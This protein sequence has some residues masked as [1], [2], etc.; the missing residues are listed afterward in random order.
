VYVFPI[1]LPPLRERRE[2]VPALVEHFSAQISRQNG[3]KPA[4]FTPEAIAHLQAQP[5]TGNIRE[6]RNVVERL[7]LF[8]N[9]GVV[10][11]TT[12]ASALPAADSAGARPP[13]Q[14]STGTLADRVAAMERET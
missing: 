10:D 14:T 5:W 13:A 2:D 9:D 8:A 4:R 12:V 1:V 6:L 3:W 11:E 7:L